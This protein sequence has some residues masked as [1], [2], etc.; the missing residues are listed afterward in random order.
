MGAVSQAGGVAVLETSI[1]MSLPE[2]DS[3]V[4]LA[5]ALADVGPGKPLESEG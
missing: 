3:D 4:T 1:D 5:A 2:D